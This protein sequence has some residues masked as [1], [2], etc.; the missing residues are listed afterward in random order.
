V[1][2]CRGRRTGLAI[3]AG[4]LASGSPLA[5]QTEGTLGLGASLVEYDGFLASGAVVLA[6]AL[7]F[8]SPRLSFASQGSWTVFESG[9][10]VI[11]GSAAAGW[12][13]GSSGSW[14]LEMS[15]SAGAA[16]YAGSDVT[17]HLLAGARLHRFAPSAKA[18]GWIGVNAGESFGEPSGTPVELA[19]AGWSVRNRLA[20]VGTAT[21]TW[22][23][24][25]RYLDL[26]GA[27]RWTSPKL[28]LEARAGARPWAHDPEGA[29]T[30]AYGEIT[31]TVP[32]GRWLS[33]SLG[34]GKYP[35]DPVRH[36]LGATYLS[37]GLTLRGFGKPARS[38]PVHTSGVLRDR[39]VPTETSGPPL[40]IAGS[41]E[42]RTL[43]VRVPDA[44]SVE[45]MGDFTDWVP[46]RL[47]QVA[48]AVWEIELVVP[49]GV[50]RV[51]IRLNGGPWSA[52][53]GARLE[54][55]E[56]GGAV[57]IVVVP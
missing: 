23:G 10:G 3:A 13:A 49:T 57:G 41:A 34:G 39:L 20:L 43:R 16:Q 5:G 14:R 50:H 51:N 36:T 35:S 54:R 17:G 32:L 37:A 46:V 27:A 4:I 19:V 24:R 29:V 28:E 12:L 21:T 53:G 47:V 1:V 31:A 33:L 38:A 42:R 44:A 45:L 48:P 18:G 8:D 55:T 30:E 2:R 56:F 11:Q 6:P 40:E 52:P 9:R 25:I 26:A 22:Q 15:G 7:R